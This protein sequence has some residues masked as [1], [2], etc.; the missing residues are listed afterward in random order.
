MGLSFSLA[1]G[2]AG[3]TSGAL[4]MLGRNGG[5][6]PGKLAGKIDPQILADLAPK[7]T[8]GSILVVATNGKT[9]VT[10]LVADMLEADGYTVLCNRGGA[11]MP[12]GLVS[13]LLTAEEAQWGVFETDELYLGHILGQLQSDYVLLMDIFPDQ[14]DR[15]GGTGRLVRSITAAL[16]SCPETTLVYNADDPNCRE[17][18]KNIPNPT[19]AIGAAERFTEEDAVVLASGLAVQAC[20]H[21]SAPLFYAWRQYGPLGDYLCPTCGLSR[22]DKRGLDVAICQGQVETDECS[23][24]IAFQGEDF[25]REVAEAEMVAPAVPAA[26]EDEVS[27]DEAPNAAPASS[28]NS[29]FLRAP[30]GAAY[31]VYNLTFAATMARLLGVNEEVA[32]AAI[33]AFDPQNGRMETLCVDGR[34]TLVNLAK[35]PVGFDQNIQLICKHSEPCVVGFFVNNNVGDGLDFSWVG[36]VNFEA[37]GQRVREGSMRVFADGMCKDALL[38]ALQARGVDASG[39]E[40]AEEVLAAAEELPEDGRVYLIANYTALP[41]VKSA[42]ERAAQ[43]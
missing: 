35:N 38:R 11:N 16:A 32:Q 12:Q 23:W 5:A 27:D 14:L 39:C 10:N 17:V 24:K 29:W 7:I 25:L 4:R 1:K 37:L 30:Y 41:A 9:T 33:D 20:P 34:T 15:M 31:M 26:E 21:C 36:K 28:P 6:L 18:A 40:G 8:E 43:A 3:V 22:G 42:A 13:V 2:V 19:L